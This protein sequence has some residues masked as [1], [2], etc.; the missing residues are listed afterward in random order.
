MHLR[1]YIVNLVNFALSTFD[2]RMWEINFM[3]NQRKNKQKFCGFSK[4]FKN[5]ILIK[6]NFWKL[7][8]NL[9]WGHARSHKKFGP[10]R[11]SR[12]DVYWLQ[13]NKQTPRHPKSI[14]IDVNRWCIFISNLVRPARYDRTGTVCYIWSECLKLP[15]KAFC[16]NYPFK[17]WNCTMFCEN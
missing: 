1:L 6:A 7:S 3:T 14:H 2:R 12:F 15:T 8:L 10:D 5:Q 4:I 16:F 11:F 17:D 13:T 9:P